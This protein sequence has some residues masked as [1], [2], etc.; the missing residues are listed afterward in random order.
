MQAYRKNEKKETGGR[1]AGETSS[2]A[3]SA[4]VCAA[5]GS[6]VLG[7]E[8]TDA[9]GA[10]PGGTA[11]SQVG[12][13]AGQKTV[14]QAVSCAADVGEA[15]A[16]PACAE[17]SSVFRLSPAFC[18]H[19]KVCLLEAGDKVT[20]GLCD[21]DDYMLKKRIRKVFDISESRGRQLDFIEI[22]EE[23]CC[24]SIA[25]VL[26]DISSGQGRDT[27]SGE[28]LSPLPDKNFSRED[29]EPA[30]A[31]EAFATEDF[32]E[33][34]AVS[35]LDSVIIEALT[36][37]VSDIHFEPVVFQDEKENLV[38]R[39]RKNGELMVYKIT[40]ISF[41]EPVILRIKMLAGLRTE[42]SRRPQDGRFLWR[43]SNFSADI[44]VSVIPLWRGESAVLRLIKR[45]A[46]PVKLSELGFSEGHLSVLKKVL[47]RRSSLILVAG[48]T[49]AGKT[50]T[51]AGMLSFLVS[52]R[53]KIISIE[54]P[55]EYRIPGVT[56]IEVRPAIQFDFED[57]LRHVFRH[58]P[59]VLMIG[60][61]RDGKTAV[62]A[63][64]AAV[65]GHLV[66][67]TIHASNACSAVIRLLDMGIEPYFLASVFG[68]A[69]AQ[70]LL[71]AAAGGRTVVAEILCG[72]EAV[73][74]L[75]GEKARVS[76]LAG[77]MH[78]QGMVSLNEDFAAKQAA[79]IIPEKELF[80]E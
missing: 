36:D 33:S 44:R 57:A 43:N 30:F 62:T 52:E 37:N 51:I 64:R 26:A 1:A 76:A 3:S 80:H 23:E 8:A 5:G 58:D 27:A 32:A 24:R 19:N 10:S 45:A 53:R 60:E 2:G 42:E 70:C 75:I 65:T 38:I 41:L 40:E 74:Q 55:V 21:I 9:A 59:D 20:V 39:F 50:T 71:P 73:R 34:P 6:A 77:C 72:N 25:R 11:A 66:L 17:S 16:C 69:V 7:L 31:T 12:S 14:C 68:A 48:P 67:A 28:A 54:D 15:G 63:V 13:C 49:G 61:I 47:S 22:S 56:Q 79:G 18:L 35:I 46:S 4:R 29:V 78:E